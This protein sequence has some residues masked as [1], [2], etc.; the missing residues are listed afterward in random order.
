M[1]IHH[2]GG[3]TL[4]KQNFDHEMLCYFAGNDYS[5][6]RN[7]RYEMNFYAAALLGS[8]RDQIFLKRNLIASG[9]G[10]RN[11]LLSFVDI[12]LIEGAFKFWLN[13]QL[14][15]K[16]VFIDSGAFSAFT[17]GAVIDIQKYCDWLK[18]N[19]REITVYAGLDV[20]GDW[21]ASAK[22]QAYMEAHGLNPILAFHYGSPL[23]ELERICKAYDYFAFG[24]MVSLAKKRNEMVAWLDRCFAVVK[25]FWPKK[26][27]CF[28]V[29]A[30]PILERYPFYSCD[31]TAAIM[32]GGMGR[33]MD[34]KNGRL[35][36]SDW[37]EEL[38][39]GH[40][41]TADKDGK[42]GHLDRRIHNI[43]AMGAFEKYIT[44]LWAKRG[45]VWDG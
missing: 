27:H 41:Q 26:V 1:V 14:K 45:I 40:Y 23:S 36:H 2:A 7:D 44:A 35:L 43:K 21:Q 42:S 37:V 20:I 34:F 3:G 39:A 13:P 6:N 33:V 19:L 22:N 10:L 29:T 24:G 31:S 30:Q 12:N 38:Y 32:G 8:G 9:V 18:Q 15:D 5:A 28:G 4:G 11:R 16:K 25:K 17:R